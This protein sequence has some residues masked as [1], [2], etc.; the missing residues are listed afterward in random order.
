MEHCDISDSSSQ[1]DDVAKQVK[2]QIFYALMDQVMQAGTFNSEF[3]NRFADDHLKTIEERV[4]EQ[5]QA[6]DDLTA[7]DAVRLAIKN[8]YADMCYSISP[9]QSLASQRNNIERLNEAPDVSPKWKELLAVWKE[10]NSGQYRHALRQMGPAV[11]RY[12]YLNF[13]YSA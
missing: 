12:M 1:N 2:D 4:E 3:A 11:P 13:I 7:D 10:T 5:N 8:G 6:D 9:R